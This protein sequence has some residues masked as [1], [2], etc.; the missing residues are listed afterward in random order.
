MCIR[1]SANIDENIVKGII[2]SFVT[3]GMKDAGY[4]YVNIDDAWQVARTA[5][6]T[7]IPDPVRFPSGM[8]ALSA[9]AHSKGLK[10]GLYTARGSGTCQGR[11]GSL[12]H[13]YIDAA[14]YCDWEIDY[15]KIDRC[16]GAQDENT[17]W[18]RFHEGR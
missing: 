14:T 15:I 6:G 11:P 5:N 12:N 16:R 7:I 1:D 18:S 8:K 9:Y 4:E 10:F 3:N 2:D 17:S 13:E